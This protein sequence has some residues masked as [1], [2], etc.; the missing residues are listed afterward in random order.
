MQEIGRRLGRSAPTISRATAA[1][2]S[3]PQR[4]V[5][6]RATGRSIRMPTEQSPSAQADQ[7]C[8][9]RNLAHLYG[10]ETCWLGQSAPSSSP[11]PSPILSRG[12]R[13]P[14]RNVQR[15]VLAL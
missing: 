3:H 5:E 7:A 6:Y 14:S 2:R 12:S 4:R 10:G 8:V 15:H 13:A 1:Q 11:G 9:P